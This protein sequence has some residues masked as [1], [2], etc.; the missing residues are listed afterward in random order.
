M[1]FKI[2]IIG[3]GLIFLAGLYVLSGDI[4]A[5]PSS[6]DQI[7]VLGDKELKVEI[8]DTPLSR[9]E[10]L[11]GREGLDGGTGLLFVFESPETPGFW[12][13]DMNFSIDI[14]WFDEGKNLID[15]TEDITPET[16]PET[17]YP[18]QSILYALETNVDEFPSIEDFI[19]KTFE[20][21]TRKSD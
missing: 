21:S 5:T 9:V 8:V 20:L 3:A 13:K 1:K 11:S 6:A 18:T 14:L 16:Y 2:F 15:I 19:G 7:L 10:G 12:M 17:F 4:V